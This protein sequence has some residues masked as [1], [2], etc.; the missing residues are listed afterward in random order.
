MNQW[1][2]EN[3]NTLYI[4]RMKLRKD[5]AVHERGVN[6]C[7]MLDVL[8]W[9][10]W[11][12]IPRMSFDKLIRLTMCGRLSGLSHIIFLVVFFLNMH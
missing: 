5:L 3:E 6:A 10:G 8:A 1:R 4:K 7:S 11:R 9:E 2:K 12:E